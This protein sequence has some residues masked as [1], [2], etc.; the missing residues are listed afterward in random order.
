[1]TPRQRAVAVFA[2]TLAMLLWFA[3]WNAV[4][5]HWLDRAVR[6]LDVRND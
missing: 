3:V 2:P 1:M 5:R 4:D 6:W